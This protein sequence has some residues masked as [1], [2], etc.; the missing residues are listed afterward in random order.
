MKIINL[1]FLICICSSVSAQNNT[2][3]GGGAASGSGGS[4]SYTIGQVFYAALQGTNG[5]LIQGVQQ[6]FEISIVTSTEDISMDLKA[7]VYPNPS[8]D[9]LILSINSLEL[10]NLQYMLYDLQGH[11]ISSNRI[12]QNTSIIPVSQLSNGTYFLRILSNKKQIRTF[13]II[14][15]K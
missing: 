13:Q 6:P 14:K 15:N 4:V 9:H 8:S 5:S 12:R 10:K 3:S 7:Q 11:L 2:V 1:V